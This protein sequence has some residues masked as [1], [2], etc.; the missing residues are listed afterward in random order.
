MRFAVV[1]NSFVVILNC[2]LLY[3]RQ[4]TNNKLWRQLE[5]RL[6]LVLVTLPGPALAG[7]I[8]ILRRYA[9]WRSLVR[10]NCSLLVGGN[11]FHSDV[12]KQP[13]LGQIINKVTLH[14]MMVGVVVLLSQHYPTAAR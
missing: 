10:V 14:K 8:K 7:P 13:A 11:H 5:G 1:G 4:V 3:V 2:V 9:F 12:P 6:Y